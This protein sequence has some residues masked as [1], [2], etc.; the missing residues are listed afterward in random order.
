M[1]QTSERVDSPVR[2]FDQLF[3]GGAWTA[4]AT[5]DVI[6]VVSPIDGK[7]IA[8]VPEAREADVDRAVAAAR[9]AFDEGPWPRMSPRR[10]S[11]SRIAPRRWVS[12]APIC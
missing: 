1:T 12:S 7:V 10:G 11:F 9:K 2:S 4:P 5:S 3:I 8:T 6:E